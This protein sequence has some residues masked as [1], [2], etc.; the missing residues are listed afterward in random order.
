MTTHN[1]TSYVSIKGADQ[2]AEGLNE[3]VEGRA[4]CRG[5]CLHPSTENLRFFSWKCYILIH[6]RAFLNKV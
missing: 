4:W 2:G 6:L 3:G 1:G 5:K